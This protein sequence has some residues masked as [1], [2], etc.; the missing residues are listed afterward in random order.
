MQQKDNSWHINSSRGSWQL[1]NLILSEGMP[2]L[3]LIVAITVI[4][5]IFLS[6]GIISDVIMGKML[7]LKERPDKP[8][9][10]L[11]ACVIDFTRHQSL[12]QR[13]YR[14]LGY[15]APRSEQCLLLV[16]EMV[17]ES[18]RGVMIRQ[19]SA[20]IRGILHSSVNLPFI[21][22]YYRSDSKTQQQL[23]VVLVLA[24]LGLIYVDRQYYLDMSILPRL[25]DTKY[26][27][28]P[29]KDLITSVLPGLVIAGCSFD[30]YPSHPKCYIVSTAGYIL[31]NV[32]H[33]YVLY[34]TVIASF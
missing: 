23:L 33:F 14:S 28:D 30:F 19:M 24:C 20:T 27:E 9:P 32:F 12:I 22:L 21:V 16:Q 13:F 31:L 17:K 1:Y 7:M 3:L 8:E 5:S 25:S 18:I 26:G 34:S 4:T 29:G 2:S 11:S 10:Y 6:K 15:E